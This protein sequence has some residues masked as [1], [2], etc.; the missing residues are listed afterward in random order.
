MYGKAVDMAAPMP[1]DHPPRTRWLRP[2]EV[3]PDSK[4]FSLS[5]GVQS[6]LVR[7]LRRV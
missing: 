1:P 4:T 3:L 6:K 5:F 7:A 2:S